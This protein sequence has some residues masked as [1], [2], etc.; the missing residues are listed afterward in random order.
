M[1]SCECSFPPSTP[2]HTLP[3]IR[4]YWQD[5]DQYI[6]HRPQRIGPPYVCVAWVMTQPCSH[7][8]CSTS[9]LDNHPSVDAS[10]HTGVPLPAGHPTGLH[11]TL[12]GPAAQPRALLRFFIFLPNTS[13]RRF[14]SRVFMA[15]RRSTGPLSSANCF[16]LSQVSFLQYIQVNTLCPHSIT[17]H[18]MIQTWTCCFRT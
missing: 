14:E 1:A 17:T 10:Y 3:H 2:A 18:C 15:S 11:A 12:A 7:T 8:A 13:G 9:V 16:C 6:G 4:A 5:I